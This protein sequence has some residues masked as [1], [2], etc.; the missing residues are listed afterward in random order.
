MSLRRTALGILLVSLVSC[1]APSP[2]PPPSGPRVHHV[3]LCWLATPGD[4]EAAARLAKTTRDLARLPGV[5]ELRTGGPLPSDR[6]VV[7]D[8]F[9]LGIVMTFAD[10]DALAA[11]LA[12]PDHLRAVDE[13]LRPLVARMVVYD[14]LE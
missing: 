14:I 4:A 2:E 12:H 5:L 9:D 1:A 3:V 11:Y 13:V 6:P 7:D 10:P 8:S